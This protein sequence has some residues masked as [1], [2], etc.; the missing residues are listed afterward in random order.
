LDSY[1]KTP[2][3]LKDHQQHPLS[4]VAEPDDIANLVLFL[5]SDKAGFIT[6]QN[7]IADGGMTLKMIYN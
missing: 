4:R 2:L 3:T 7:F 6:G 1:G 5:I